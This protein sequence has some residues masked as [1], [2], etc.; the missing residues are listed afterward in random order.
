LLVLWSAQCSKKIGVG[1]MDVVPSKKKEI[2]K[3]V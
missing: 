1:P 3:K 2:N